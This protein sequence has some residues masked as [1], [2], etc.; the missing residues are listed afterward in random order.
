MH[1][2]INSFDNL[3]IQDYEYDYFYEDISEPFVSNA[4]D[5]FYPYY[6]ENINFMD[7]TK[8]CVIPT[9]FDVCWTYLPVLF[10][11]LAFQFINIFSKYKLVKN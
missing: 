2:P 3:K 10:I 5:T 7:I 4:Y 11:C 8:S 6:M 1:Q 9:L